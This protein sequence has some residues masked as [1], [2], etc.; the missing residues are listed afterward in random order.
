MKQKI[1]KRRDI[2]RKKETMVTTFNFQENKTDCSELYAIIG[3]KLFKVSY[4]SNSVTEIYTT[5]ED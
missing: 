5:Q 4:F 1:Q 3:F 2:E